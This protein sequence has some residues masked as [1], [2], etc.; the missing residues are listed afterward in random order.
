MITFQKATKRQAK[1]RIGISGPA[2]SGKTYTALKLATAMC[3][4][5][6]VI[7]TEHGSASKYADEFSFDVLELDDFHPNNYIEAIKAAEAA[8]YDGLIIDSISHEWNGK[9]GC[10]ELVELYAKRNRGGNK[11]AAWADVTPLHNDFIEAIHASKLHIIA[12]MRSKMD[13]IQTENERGKTE[14]KKVGM[15]PITREGA[16]YEFDIV[17]EMDLDHT[18]VIT[19]SRCK[20]LA[21]RV[22]KLP[23]EDLAKEIMAWLSDGAPQTQAQAQPPVKPAQP[24]PAPATSATTPS[25]MRDSSGMFP[26]LMGLTPPPESTSELARTTKKASQ[27]VAFCDQCGASISEKVLQYSQE[28]WG[29][30]LCMKC[31]KAETSEAKAVGQ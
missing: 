19:K 25:D 6:A 9:N 14:I 31:Q 12:T 21:D 10:L 29:R 20:A 5:V 13:Y 11:Y 8:G 22:F 18:M 17:G 27:N 7:D 15:A 26:D 16:E 3:K 4:K 30:A 2:G 24:T 23:G 1:A 28:H